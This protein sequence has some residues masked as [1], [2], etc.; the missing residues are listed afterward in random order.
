M[1]CQVSSKRGTLEERFWSRVLKGEKCWEWQGY[2]CNQ[3]G[4]GRIYGKG[5]KWNAHRLSWV[6]HNGDVPDGSVIR[7]KCDN[8]KCVNP[9]HLD[10]G[11]QADNVRDMWER[12]RAVPPP[13]WNDGTA[14]PLEVR[15]QKNRERMGLRKTHCQRG[16]LLPEYIPGKKRR[17][18]EEECRE[19]WRY[20]ALGG[21][22]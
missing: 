20:N 22:N 14:E 13:R 11:T 8:R 12:G 16:H 18:M 3:T 6:V 7:H 17:C 4:Y 10:I 9:E 1:P 15:K 19:A 21:R 5:R 2:C